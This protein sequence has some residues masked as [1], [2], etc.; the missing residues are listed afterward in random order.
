MKK[1]IWYIMVIAITLVV[2]IL[3]WQFSISIILF[4][5]PWRLRL[6]CGL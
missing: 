1:V 3:I 5:C 2:L 6:P 4:A